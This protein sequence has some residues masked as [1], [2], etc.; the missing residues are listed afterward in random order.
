MAVFKVHLRQVRYV[1][2]SPLLTEF[3]RRSSVEFS[4]KIQQVED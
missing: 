1:D 4:V 3:Y 2:C